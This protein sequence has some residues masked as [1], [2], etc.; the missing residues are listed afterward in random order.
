MLYS[1]SLLRCYLTFLLKLK[2]HLR[3]WEL[4]LQGISELTKF[5]KF[6]EWIDITYITHQSI[7]FDALVLIASLS[8][9]IV[10]SQSKYYDWYE[11]NRASDLNNCLLNS[12]RFYCVNFYSFS[13][14]IILKWEKEFR[15][16]RNL[17]FN[18][19]WY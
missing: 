15:Q 16:W 7:P 9:F 17:I 8:M 19:I 3:L 1:K 4:L 11:S 12:F 6:F 5:N 18:V 14:V 10:Y 13:W 2:S